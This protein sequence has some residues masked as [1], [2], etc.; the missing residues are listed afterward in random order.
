MDGSSSL[1]IVHLTYFRRFRKRLEVLLSRLQ[2][3][4]EESNCRFSSIT[5]IAKIGARALGRGR[6]N[7]G[8][9][10]LGRENLRI[11][12]L[13]DMGNLFG[14]ISK[15]TISSRGTFVKR[16]VTS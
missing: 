10:G 3:I 13:G 4:L 5:T 2:I 6:E 11:V 15:V 16:A 9:V 8:M 1:S 14:H 12:G 7:L